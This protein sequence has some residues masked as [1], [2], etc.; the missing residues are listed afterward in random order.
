MSYTLNA[1]REMFGKKNLHDVNHGVLTLQLFFSST[2]TAER[3][4]S[5]NELLEI[6]R[7]SATI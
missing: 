5:S 3:A 4:Q 1:T 2:T 6:D 7:S